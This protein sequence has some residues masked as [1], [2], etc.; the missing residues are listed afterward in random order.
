MTL[1]VD[2]LVP[3][4]K[5]AAYRRDG[6]VCLCGVFDQKWIEALRA[7]VTREMANPSGISKDYTAEGKPGRFFGSLVMWR[8]VPE[9]EEFVR[10]SP[11]AAIA[12]GSI[13]LCRMR[14]RPHRTRPSLTLWPVSRPSHM[15]R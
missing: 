2:Q 13:E 10:H 8:Q 11:A 7:G 3:E 1:K 4:A 9:F 6:A 12:G 14:G 5:I 15:C